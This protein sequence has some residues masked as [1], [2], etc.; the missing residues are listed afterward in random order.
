MGFRVE[1]AR[2]TDIAIGQC[3]NISFSGIQAQFDVQVEK[4]S[5]GLL[6]LHHPRAL[7]EVAAVV[8]RVSEE[9]IG[10]EFR[11]KT[12]QEEHKLA[13]M[14][15]IEEEIAPPLASHPFRRELNRDDSVKRR[16]LNK[17]AR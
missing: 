13:E 10:L 15:G 3:R 14:L 11:F 17:L 5:S 16:N 12:P 8:T 2:E 4:G 9:H 7:F 6:T 1:F